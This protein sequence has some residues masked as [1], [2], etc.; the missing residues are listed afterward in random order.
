MAPQDPTLHC[1]SYC[2]TVEHH[3]AHSWAIN[4]EKIH[5]HGLKQIP[6]VS[7][8]PAG[9][10]QKPLLRAPPCCFS[11]GFRQPDMA[12][13]AMAPWKHGGGLLSPC[14]NLLTSNNSGYNNSD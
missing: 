5:P 10:R 1:M 2:S 7:P 8:E 9:L 11:K 14:N 6:V 13:M 12:D 4:I 3:F